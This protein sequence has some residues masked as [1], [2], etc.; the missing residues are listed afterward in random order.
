MPA[1]D[2]ASPATKTLVKAKIPHV[3]HS[4]DHD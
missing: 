4:Y 3:L 1:S 2:P